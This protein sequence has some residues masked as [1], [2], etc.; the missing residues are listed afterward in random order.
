MKKDFDEN[1]LL[2]VE[3]YCRKGHFN[4]AMF[5][6]DKSKE[7]K[8]FNDNGMRLYA[9]EYTR[10]GKD[11]DRANSQE[12]MIGAKQ[13]MYEAAQRLRKEAKAVLL[14]KDIN[15]DNIYGKEPTREEATEMLYQQLE[16]L[17]LDKK[18]VRSLGMEDIEKILYEDGKGFEFN[19]KDTQ[20]QREA[21]DREEIEYEARDGRL[22]A[23]AKVKATEGVA[24]EDTPENRKLLDDN[25]IQYIDMAMNVNPHLRKAVLFVPSTWKTP[26][27]EGMKNDMGQLADNVMN[28]HYT[29]NFLAVAGLIGVSAMLPFHPIWTVAA[30]IIMRK[31][32]LLNKK[33]RE[34]NPT[35]FEKEALK[36]GHTVFKQERIDGRMK[37][38]YLFMDN[39]NLMRINASD[40]RIPDY[41]KGVHLTP[42]Q[43]EQFRK[44]EPIELKD[45]R[46]QLFWAR[47][48]VSN[49][50]LYREYY[51]EM[52]SDR[53]A[54][55]VPNTRS[56]D[57][58]KLNYISKTGLSGVRAIYG[59]ANLNV[60]RDAFL[61]KYNMK[62]KF[63]EMIEIEEKL[64]NTQDQSL[65]DKYSETLKNDDRSLREIAENEVISL[66]RSNS[67][68]L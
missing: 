33:Q 68:K 2:L 45:K 66:H 41:I 25:E 36:A 12:E 27:K 58:E 26:L 48:D 52:R 39:G 42:V 16:E 22:H 60:D 64:R 28:S 57:E 29:K 15:L 38:Q 19:V 3:L 59:A 35:R 5:G 46:G 8:F 37:S 11:Y 6:G 61:S 21:F 67:R 1:S 50:K 20:K 53:T 55:P 63:K 24:L 7:Q 4:E 62:D 65:K 14:T 51:K 40:I 43:K 44:G 47:I 30:F 23:K 31:T 13:R 18:T 32:G 17:G 56:T 34:M 49:P 10:A 54:I 9:E